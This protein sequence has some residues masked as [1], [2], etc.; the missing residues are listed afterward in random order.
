MSLLQRLS[1]IKNLFIVFFLSASN[2]LQHKDVFELIRRHNL[3][4]VIHQMIVPLIQLDSDKAFT[5][6]LDMGKVPAEIVV[7]H[8]EQHEEYLF[9][10]SA[11]DLQTNVMYL[12]SFLLPAVF[13]SLR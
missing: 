2:R 12:N 10:V 3:Y 5:L 6:L 11:N 13:S 1:C 9:N 8:L 7:Q 4:D